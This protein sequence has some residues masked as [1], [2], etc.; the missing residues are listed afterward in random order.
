MSRPA[1]L[2]C[3]QVVVWLFALAAFVRPTDAYAQPGHGLE[4][5]L[6]LNA[7]VSETWDVRV[8]DVDEFGVFTAVAGVEVAFQSISQDREGAVALGKAVTR[9][10][11]ADG[12]V[13]PPSELRPGG[14]LASYSA[15]GGTAVATLDRATMRLG[16]Y[17]R[18]L[19]DTDLRAEARVN[20]EVG[21][22]GL[23]VWLIITL[24]TDVEGVRRWPA[25]APLLLPLLAPAVG[26]D[27]LDRGLVPDG[28]RAVQ[29]DVQGDAKVAAHRGA[30]T[31]VGSV[32][33]N[34][35]IQVRLR[36]PVAHGAGAI[37]LGLR[38]VVGRTDLL[39][40][41]LAVDPAAPRFETDWP[42]RVGTHRE[43]RERLAGLS[44]LR[45]IAMNEVATFAVVDLPTPPLMPRR[46]LAS[47][48]GVG[49]LIAFGAA[50]RIGRRR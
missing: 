16:R 8:G 39:V 28:A 14:A 31:L 36:Y 49:L 47:L 40:A 6:P 15:D 5:A 21:D 10:S 32:A 2:G 48:F 33:P 25:N 46:M 45:S 38:G 23:R 50:L 41:A 11:D 3:F 19:A 12:R 1:G 43:G 20:L 29:I 18:R 13:S 35:P 27:V 22:S 30:L 24:A 34:R 37:M 44:L 42:A 26:D 9:R 4:S 7:E 17:R